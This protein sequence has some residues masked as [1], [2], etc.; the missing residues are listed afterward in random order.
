[1]LDLHPSPALP[2]EPQDTSAE[3]RR[4]FLP[5]S[6]ALRRLLPW[7]LVVLLAAGAWFWWRQSSSTTAAAPAFRTARVQR[8]PIVQTVTATGP[9]SAVATVEVGSQVS[10]NIARLHVDFND[11]V[12]AGQ[13]IAEIE[14]S[15]YE[16]RLVEAE[17]DLLTARA[18]LELRQLNATRTAD[19]LGRKLVPQSEFDQARSELHQQ[20]A[21]VQVKEAAVRR[22]RVD[23]E[24]TKIR[25]PIDGVVISRTI[26]VG[27][28]V[29]ASFAAPTLFK[30]AHD[31]REMQITA[32]VSE[33]DIGAVTAGQAVAFT[34]DA[35]PGE[36]F[37]GTVREVRNDTTITNNVVTYPTII[38][39][40]NP[41]LKLRPG[42]TA[43]VTITLARRDDT[44]RV[45]NAALRYRPPENAPVLA[46]AAARSA[47]RGHTVYILRGSVDS[48]GHGSGRLEP[49]SV[50]T[51]LSDS[52]FTE[53][54][55]G[56][57]EGVIVAT[58]TSLVPAASA[59]SGVTNPFVP[60]MPP[61]GNKR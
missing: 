59:S 41:D 17:G 10:G 31:L 33:A 32:N 49:V 5:A 4:S 46:A 12:A 55:S 52:A 42:M 37:A 53:I 24:R 23:L 50:Q 7:T 22:A 57:E 30:L 21:V 2:A 54:V 28:T 3:E 58:G 43:N 34:V 51:G 18:A 25:S 48:A 29:Q 9:L 60:K 13:L 38:T 8:G 14:P 1:M 40:E 35:F 27:Q 45:P 26:D 44:L 16:A 61:R 19:L 20:Q 36:T 15:T 56:L 11:R 47:P 6:T 39:V